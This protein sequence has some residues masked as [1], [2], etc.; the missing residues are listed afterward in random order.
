MIGDLTDRVGFLRRRIAA[1][2]ADVVAT[3]SRLSASPQWY[4]PG[5]RPPHAGPADVSTFTEFERLRTAVSQLRERTERLRELLRDAERDPLRET[6]CYLRALEWVNSATSWRKL[7]R[8]L[9]DDPALDIRLRR[10]PSNVL[11]AIVAYRDS[12]PQARIRRLEDLAAVPGVGEDLL[13][14][15]V[16]T[17]CVL[18]S[19][20]A[21]RSPLPV[22]PVLLPLRLE[23]RFDPPS[24]SQPSWRLRLRVI[25][26]DATFDRF[27]PLASEGELDL[28]ER[29]WEATG[30][31]MDN[32]TGR[33]AWGELID[34][35]GGARAAW[36]VRIY[37]YGATR[38]IEVRT[39][40]F[41]GVP[42]GLPDEL[43][44][45]IGRGGA[46][47]QRMAMLTV[48]Q[49]GAARLDPPDLSISERRWWNSYAEA[50]LV[51]LATGIDLGDRA[52]DIDVVLA[53]GLSDTAPDGWYIN[54]CEHG[55]MGLLAPGVATNTVE[56][57][58][59]A[60][61][62]GD[63]DHWLRVARGEGANDPGALAVAMALT[64]DPAAAR[65]LLGGA[66]DVDSI[67]RW[68]VQGLWHALW[69]HPFKDL[70][71]LGAGSHLGG[72]W[73]AEALRPE[74]PLPTLR[75]GSQPYG[76]LA[77]TAM[78]RWVPGPNDPPF[79]AAA[80]ECLRAGRDAWASA[81]ERAG[82]VVNADTDA[83]LDIVGRTPSSDAYAWRWLVPLDLLYLL[84]WQIGAQPRW[85]ELLAL[86]NAWID[87]ARA[88]CSDLHP[89]LPLVGFGWPV[90][91]NIP[92]VRPDN[93]TDDQFSM[94]LLRLGEPRF[95]VAN[96]FEEGG[97]RVLPGGVLPNSLL[98]RLLMFAHWVAAAEVAR[99]Q[100]T[101]S[102]PRA[103]RWCW[104]QR[105]RELLHADARTMN[106][107]TPS[108]PAFELRQMLL[109]A[110]VALSQCPYDEIERAMRTVLDTASHRL[111]PWLTGYALRRLRD[112]G[113]AWPRRLGVYGWVD[114]P[115]PGAPGPTAGGLV[116]APSHAQ[117]YT[118][119]VLRDRA[120]SDPEAGR[121]DMDLDSAAVRA[122]DR[123]GAGVRAG[124]H[125]A[126]VLGAEVER[127]V[128]DPTAIDDLRAR[129]PIRVEH[130]GRRVCDGVA[131]LASDPDDLGL[132][133]GTLSAL[134]G[135]RRAVDAYGDLLV[136]Q[137]VHHV[138]SGRGELAGAAMDAAAG[139]AAP[140][141]LEVVH[142]P[143]T[144]RTVATTAIF[145][146]P[147]ATA[148][149]SGLDTSP[150]SVAEP[151]FAA[152][153]DAQ[154]GS[155]T[156]ASWRWTVETAAGGVITVTLA[157]LG[158]APHDAA[159][160]PAETMAL[161]VRAA[162][163]PGATPDPQS[164]G[165]AT[166]RRARS[167]VVMA[168]SEPAEPQHL[169]ADSRP[170]G[171]A[172]ADDLR[173]R[174]DALE[175]LAVRVRDAIAA[176]AGATPTEQ[177]TALHR[178]I[179][180]GITAIAGADLDVDTRLGGAARALTDRLGALPAPADRPA[181]SAA[182]VARHIAE[183]AVADGRWPVL[184][185][186]DL[187]ALRTGLVPAAGLDEE[188]LTVVAAVR[189]PL[190]RIEAVQ[191]HGVVSPGG[192]PL[193]AWTNRPVDPWQ[194]TG[195]RDPDTG[196]MPDSHLLVAYGGSGATAGSRC[197]VGLLDQWSE[198]VPEDEHTTTAGFGFNAPGA[199]APQAILIAVPPA[200]DGILADGDLCE[201]ALEARQL[202]R[203]RMVRP[204]DLG[205]VSAVAPS[206]LLPASPSVGVELQ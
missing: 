17:G 93:M 37:P 198:V 130:A 153:V 138:V 189:P 25:P 129:F 163:G 162:G 151:A 42:R 123:L 44:V 176:A 88:V 161:L 121:W 85:Q 171:Q 31:D 10:L 168:G 111:D 149:D 67:G 100:Q 172:I 143:R 3:A 165:F 154:T 92:L 26:D 193:S 7:Q 192:G 62:D 46:A 56:G 52:D 1:V 15:I 145:L 84:W 79:E 147:D 108:G 204:T 86:Y 160:I 50:E 95:D 48:D 133:A 91:L 38:P 114:S 59:A 194:K 103:P 101:L 54:Q 131:V 94:L 117:A 144:G 69:G 203:V 76:L 206:M 134:A 96:L 5:V 197:S 155:A 12:Q 41:F 74:G 19:P 77:V 82:T 23:T 8:E 187:A 20:D 29:L 90:D 33:A 11:Q 156:G 181:L 110:C 24:G 9:V 190:A 157:D 170:S 80:Y 152:F 4:Q 113:M 124:G 167:L 146:L 13:R 73:A 64:G 112:E 45:W 185:R 22:V 6:R 126:E 43:E 68:L 183:L 178:A 75:I 137:A 32:V 122:A 18:L 158:L 49:A 109:E 83:L 196:R 177:A 60:S 66:T 195:V 35:V 81:A 132:P 200:P 98:L 116:H 53:V 115:R 63:A 199:R 107:N 159:V 39:D 99:E 51:G 148:G 104:T 150:T 188:W 47:P 34:R 30:G 191:L 173:T 174:L 78:D 140:P 119:M 169:V 202:A 105:E 180:W 28:V 184:G 58:P 106:H 135:L 166:H 65:P 2:E 40:P 61:L 182:G 36:L 87:G 128:G 16:Y 139:L 72:L 136:A 97:W 125:L 21:A 201:I 57:E 102:G 89:Q 141:T 186:I 120:T 118:A 127:V 164:A 142:T 27:D 71:G 70:F 14:S 55:A 205:S 175:T 179:R